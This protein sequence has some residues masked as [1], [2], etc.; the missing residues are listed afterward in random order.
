MATITN[1]VVTL[2]ETQTLVRKSE[3][4]GNLQ[5]IP[6]DL[7]GLT[8]GDTVIFTDILPD[9]T[10]AV[11]LAIRP[12]STNTGGTLDIGYT[13]DADAIR[14]DVDVAAETVIILDNTDVSG[15]QLIGTVETAVPA[16][17]FAGYLTYVCDE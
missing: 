2:L 1:A 16:S 6:I 5:W 9:N 17:G 15:L 3:Y 10:K 13:G 4:R 11:S 7:T 8:I 12:L 14:V